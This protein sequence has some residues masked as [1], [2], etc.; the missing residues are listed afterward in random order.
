MVAGLRQ[1]RAPRRVGPVPDRWTRTHHHHLPQPR[2]AGLG[3]PAGGR[4]AVSGR[5]RWSCSPGGYP[6]CRRGWR[7]R[8][9]RRWV[10]CRLALD[11][12]VGLLRDTGMPVTDYLALLACRGWSGAG[13][14]SRPGRAGSHGR[15]ILDGGVRPSRRRQPGGAAAVEPG[16]V[17]GARTHPADRVHPASRA[18]PRSSPQHRR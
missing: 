14:P 15:R 12:A 17:A 16:G 7:I 4:G 8:L 6:T 10:T 1:R 5:S 2:L 11:Q 3:D 18:A 13:P 9:P